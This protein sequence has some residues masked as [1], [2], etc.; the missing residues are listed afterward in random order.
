MTQQTAI[1]Q[2][3][4]NTKLDEALSRAGLPVDYP[5][6]GW[7]DRDLE[8]A[9]TG[10]E[11]WVYVSRPDRDITLDE[12]LAELK[13]DATPKHNFPKDCRRSINAISGNCASTSARSQAGRPLSSKLGLLLFFAERPVLHQADHRDSIF[14]SSRPR[15]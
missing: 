12:R 13:N 5:I 8:I 11:P 3:F 6:R 9:D 7:L 10:R 1:Q 14:A 15:P 4:V 2:Q